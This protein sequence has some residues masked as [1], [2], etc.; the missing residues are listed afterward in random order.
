M[1]SLLLSVFVFLCI[2]PLSS[3]AQENQAFYRFQYHKL[4]WKA[5]HEKQFSIYFPADA[6]DSIYRFV[7]KELPYAIEVIKKATIKEVPKNL[8]IVIYPSG[9]QFYESNIGSY[10]Q[11]QFTVPMFVYK[12]TRIVLGYS[13]SYADLKEQL[14]EGLARALWESQLKHEDLK[15]SSPGA[16]NRSVG[17]MAT[18]DIPMWYSEGSIRYFA[19]GWPVSSE[20][21]LRLSFEEQKFSSWNAVLNYE[22]RLA[23]QAFC[24]FLTQRYY[25][26][27]VAQMVF[28]LQ[29]KKSLF[30][31]I[32]RVTGYSLDTLCGQC[33]QYYKNRFPTGKDIFQDTVRLMTIP[34]K[35]GIISNVLFNNSRDRVAYTC[36]AKGKKTVYIYDIREET[37]VKAT[38]YKLPP[39]ITDHTSDP[40]PLLVWHADS[41]Y[42]DVVV[43]RKGI[44]NA[45]T[46]SVDGKCEGHISFDGVDGIRG[47]Q[48]LSDGLY[49]LGAYKKGQSDIVTYNERKVKYKA[50]TDDEYDDE[51]PLM[52][53]IDSGLL[54]VSDRP[55]KFEER[56][57]YLIGVGF[58]KDTLYQGVYKIS[59]KNIMPLIIDSIDYVKWDK[60]VLLK[61]HRLFLSSTKYGMGKTVLLKEN[62]VVI[63]SQNYHPFQY[64]ADK[65]ELLFNKA[66]KDSIHVSIQ[67]VKEWIKTADPGHSDTASQWL[68]DRILIQSKL[69][70]EDSIITYSKDTTHFILDDVFAQSQKDKKGRKKKDKGVKGDGT[71]SYILQLHSAYFTAQVN[72]DY[73]INRYQPYVNYQGQFKFPEVGGMTKG[74]F[75][76]LLENHHFNIAY[77]LPAAT[78]G[79]D[80]NI[81]YENTAQKVDW[82]FSYFRKVETL[83]PDPKRNW[84]D[85]NGRQYPSNAKVKTHYYEFFVRRPLTFYSAITLQLALR[86]DRT[87]FLATDNYT[88]DFP[89]LENAW[90]INTLSYKINKLNPTLPGLFTGYKADVFLDGFK[91]SDK[92]GPFVFGLTTSVEWHKPLYKYITLVAQ[93]HAGNSGGDEKILY[94]LGGTNNNVTPQQ[95]TSVHFAQTAPYA[96][97]T[98][99]TPFRGRLQ[100]SL[101][102]NQY[103]LLNLDVYFPIFQTLIPLQT[104]LPFINNLQLGMLC[105]M[106]AAKETWHIPSAKGNSSV[107]YGISMKSSL[108]G[109]PL[110]IDLAWPG[111]FSR[112]PVWYFSLSL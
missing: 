91:G 59:G 7:A 100:N 94:N 112:K 44:L 111:T 72:N 96:F 40:Y 99:V 80:I 2:F 68:A 69:T 41:H 87:I 39:W 108:A 81:R 9:S 10:E 43:P 55:K 66:D 107:S 17:S 110:R 45:K 78:E 65:D 5:Y 25:P 62:G 24:Y 49:L 82:G 18:D 75:T 79:S 89:A 86:K 102:G 90:S 20:N 11:K 33:F 35:R 63:S 1:K 93:L 19:H 83:K 28:Q 97:Q 76:D 85:E 30:R 104:P 105:D 26:K 4:K 51:T 36:L 77:R 23:G 88:L 84:V 50:H 109:Y 56:K 52:T 92:G 31:V 71:E 3:K 106:A 54:F 103:A 60:P 48:L 34:H 46:Y 73:F 16:K 101:Y 53:G 32:N 22:S 27:V 15:S 12:G 8:N 95:D 64:L 74:G 70:R 57:T 13:G 61:D 42:I 29:K 98:L 14:Y 38:T 58:K 37:T 67:S 47:I 21:K 6:A